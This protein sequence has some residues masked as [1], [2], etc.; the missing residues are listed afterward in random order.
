VLETLRELFRILSYEFNRYS[1][2]PETQ[3][4]NLIRDN[5][6][7]LSKLAGTLSTVRGFGLYL[8][9]FNNIEHIRNNVEIALKMIED[10][11]VLFK[12]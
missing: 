5:L 11:I 1:N 2:F 7:K 9:G 4:S 6:S 10:T 8:N 3:K 12:K